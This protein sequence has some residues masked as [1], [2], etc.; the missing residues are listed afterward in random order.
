MEDNGWKIHVKKALALYIL[1]SFLF[2]VS[3]SGTQLHLP[4]G[5]YLLCTGGAY[6]DGVV[7]LDSNGKI[8]FRLDN[9]RVEYC[10]EKDGALIRYSNRYQVRGEIPD[11]CILFIIT[12][13]AD[14]Q[15]KT[16][17][18]DVS[19][20]K[21]MVPLAESLMGCALDDGRMEH[22]SIN[23]KN[24]GPDCKPYKEKKTKS[25][26]FAN[27]LVLENRYDEE[28]YSYISDTSGNVYM[29]GPM[30]YKKNCDSGMPLT[31]EKNVSIEKT[32]SDKYMIISYDFH[33][34]Q[35]NG[36]ILYSGRSYLCD[37]DGRILYPEWNYTSVYYPKDQFGFIDRKLL[38]LMNGEERPLH[39]LDLSTGKEPKL[40]PEFQECFNMG[41]GFFLLRQ[42]SEYTIYNAATQEKGA[43]FHEKDAGPIYVL[44]LNSY[45]IDKLCD[46]E[47]V[48]NGEELRLSD[49]VQMAS[50]IPG[51]YPIV[52][53]RKF[54]GS[55]YVSYILNP[56]GELVLKTGRKVEYA[57]KFNYLTV[58]KGEYDIWDYKNRKIGQYA[59]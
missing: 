47:I 43:T 21:W 20:K 8:V 3:C 57:G 27:G 23:Y 18:W 55:N 25:F 59:P 54:H 35:E 14:D 38:I 53:V 5:K 19:T 37:M 33:R 13:G 31:L 6:Q 1:G 11:D 7:V 24:Y 45:I 2:L 42:G 28:G 58:G 49:T 30:F 39:Y 10:M 16:G 34:S 36:R 26:E 9:A 56:K 12:V 32:V 48:I 41:N 40:P 51:K 4:K 52:Q 17:V 22:F 44:G 15:A 46:Y 50:I 29:D